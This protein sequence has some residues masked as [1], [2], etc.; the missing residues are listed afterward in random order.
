MFQTFV[1]FLARKCCGLR[2]GTNNTRHTF[3]LLMSSLLFPCP[4]YR[5]GRAQFDSDPD[6]HFSLFYLLIWTLLY[7]LSNLATQ[8]L[9]MVHGLGFGLRLQR[10]GKSGSQGYLEQKF[11]HLLMLFSLSVLLFGR[12]E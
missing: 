12:E 1:R 5:V 10:T 11:L 9:S 6:F 3:D 7:L 8:L 2:N 4:W